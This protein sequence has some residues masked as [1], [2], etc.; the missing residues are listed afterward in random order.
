MKL[1]PQCD[2][3]YEDDQGFCDMDGKELVCASAPIADEAIVAT[4]VIPTS[5][6]LAE[7]RSRGF[8]AAVIVVV[9]L[10]AL[11][12]VLYLVRARQARSAPASEA[13][14]QM[15]DRS[16]GQSPV[17]STSANTEAR[18]S[19]SDLVSTAAPV[20]NSEQSPELLANSSSRN[21]TASA[22][23]SS[24]SK[25]AL[26]HTRLAAS[27]VSAGAAAGNNRGSVVVRLNNGASIKADEA[28][29]K[30]EG[31]W[32]R[33]A[34]MVTFLKRSSVRS[35]DRVAPPAA[36]SKPVANSSGD[37]SKKNPAPQNQLRFARLEPVD[38]KKPSRFS[39]FLKKTGRVLKKPFRM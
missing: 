36:E 19:G 26:A 13:S 10:T 12:V 33:Q 20:A 28:W 39:S 8:A 11:V 31:V 25:T 5:E 38:A 21:E 35:I 6:L 4:S 1:C 30:K 7:P 17:Q 34:G 18:P 22:S 2:F 29:E 16:A 27:P 3:I 32:Y 24:T 9:V 15:P 23:Q 14:T 37:K